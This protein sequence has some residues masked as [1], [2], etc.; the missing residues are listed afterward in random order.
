M[1][2]NESGLS[3]EQVRENR[4][5]S[6]LNVLPEKP[7]PSDIVLF[8]RQL[9]NP[10]IYVLLLAGLITIVIGHF[11]DAV[12]ILL[13]VGV[14]TILGFVQERKA[15]NALHALKHFVTS[16]VTAIRDG[17]RVVVETSQLVP[18]DVVILFPNTRGL[19]VSPFLHRSDILLVSISGRTRPTD[20]M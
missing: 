3:E 1:S 13:A 14:N 20:C 9:Q 5:R 6:G 17:K 10:L 19:I 7:P 12:I 16:S 8:V 11:S 4:S 15:A 18:G 2:P